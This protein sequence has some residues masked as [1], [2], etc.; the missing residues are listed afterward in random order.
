MQEPR[1]LSRRRILKT[2][3]LFG[4]AVLGTGLGRCLAASPAPRSRFSGGI[5]LLA[6]G[7]FGTHNDKQKAIAHRMNAFA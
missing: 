4:S 1:N 2:T 7:D 3:L 6:F 5:H